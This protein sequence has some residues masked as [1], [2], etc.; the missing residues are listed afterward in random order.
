LCAL[1][2]FVFPVG[3]FSTAIAE[4]V[5]VLERSFGVFGVNAFKAAIKIGDRRYFSQI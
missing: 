2:D 1:S 3:L 5:G 4:I